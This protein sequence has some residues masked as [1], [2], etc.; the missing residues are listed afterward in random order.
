MMGTHI[1]GITAMSKLPK[2]TTL[3]LSMLLLSLTRKSTSLSTPQPATR[4]KIALIT[5]ANK[6]IGK[7][8]ARRLG[9]DPDFTAVIASRD[10]ELGR[11]A[12]ED[13]RANPGKFSVHKHDHDHDH[14]HDHGD[15]DD[16]KYEC[17][18]ISLPMALDL[19]DPTSTTN[20]VK[21][22]EENY[23]VLDVLINNAAVCFNDPTLYGKVEYTPF[24]KQAGIT[25][26][27]NFFGT[28]DVTTSFLPL[29]KK[30]PSPRIINIAS[31][32][33]RL[34]ILRS[35]EL[36]NKFTSNALDIS[37]LSTLMKQFQSDVEDGTHLEKGWPNTCY[38]VSKL[39]II[40]M[41]RVL[42]REHPEMMINS[43]DPGYCKTDQNDNRG[44]VDPKDGAYTPYLLSL[45]EVGGDDDYDDDEEEDGEAND[46][47]NDDL[48]AGDENDAGAEGAE[49]ISG[50]HFYEEQEMPWTYQ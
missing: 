43:V 29:L 12:A 35:P 1:S 19:T 2:L 15:D 21:Y 24:E 11:K 39:G 48:F 45:M 4:K 36:V 26:Q 27:T 6:G 22:I 20:A 50:L 25:I 31:A 44:T 49:T 13:L 8:I 5:G 30:S 23:G 38:G 3:V 10:P 33:G 32:A 41:T 17:D 14:D 42:A 7:E 40:A 47:A 28:L 18:V 9:T 16:C 46:E 34:T 37:K